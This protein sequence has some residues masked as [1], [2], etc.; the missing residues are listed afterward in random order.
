MSLVTQ[1]PR[2]AALPLGPEGFATSS[3]LV[4][5]LSSLGNASSNPG[6]PPANHAPAGRFPARENDPGFPVAPASTAGS[7]PC[8]P[9]DTPPPRNNAAADAAADRGRRTGCNGSICAARLGTCPAPSPATAPATIPSSSFPIR[10]TREE[11]PSSRR[12]TFLGEDLEEN[13]P[14]KTVTFKP[15][16]EDEFHPAADNL[17]SRCFSVV[18]SYAESLETIGL[19]RIAK[20]ARERLQ[21]HAGG[22]SLSRFAW[23][24]WIHQRENGCDV[25][26]VA[27]P[28]DFLTDRV[29]PLFARDT[30]MCDFTEKTF[31]LW[32][33]QNN[34]ASPDDW[35]RRSMTTATP[36]GLSASETLWFAATDSHIA[37]WLRAGIIR[38]RDDVIAAL[39]QAGARIE[40]IYYTHIVFHHENQKYTLKGGKYSAKFPFDTTSG[41]ANRTIGRDPAARE[42]EIA[43]LVPEVADLGARRAEVFERFTR[44]K[45]LENPRGFSRRVAKYLPG[46]AEWMGEM[47]REFGKKH[48]HGIGECA[49]NQQGGPH[50]VAS[51]PDK[52]GVDR[53]AFDRD[54]G[55]NCRLSNLLRPTVDGVKDPAGKPSAGS[56]HR[57]GAN[58]RNPSEIGS[59]A[60]AAGAPEPLLRHG[61]IGLGAEQYGPELGHGPTSGPISGCSAESIAPLSRPTKYQPAT[62]WFDDYFGAENELETY[63]KQQSQRKRHAIEIAARIAECAARATASLCSAAA[64]LRKLGQFLRG[65][66]SHLDRENQRESRE[67]PS[68][69]FSGAGKPRPPDLRTGERKRTAFGRIAEILRELSATRAYCADALEGIAA[70]R[71]LGAL[72]QHA[73]PPVGNPQTVR[74]DP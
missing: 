68:G 37:D 23:S 71:P 65:G 12:K 27:I 69:D 1:P 3:S 56:N 21:M 49:P 66:P 48:S 51:M 9:D 72:G 64:N 25:H 16:E 53:S 44:W 47:A 38:S 45:S 8:S 4:T 59:A 17:S 67:T 60:H 6:S 55:T 2:L 18:T 40:G 10:L 39:Q 41:S 70:P 20:E 5:H 11:H 62:P 74:M 33:L 31:R 19:D 34:R 54:L 46:N 14:K 28:L 58:R 43:R 36:R 61:W 7:P 52:N 50:H 30:V 13:P 63:E 57:E 73:S 26:I 35:W 22:L 32:D 29:L 42:A 15:P 24:F